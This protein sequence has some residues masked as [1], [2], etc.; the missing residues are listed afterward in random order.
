VFLTD[1]HG[2]APEHAPDYPVLWVLTAGGQPPAVWG[3]VLRLSAPGAG[4]PGVEL[5]KS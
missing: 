1:G 2:D 4:N 5:R 3:N